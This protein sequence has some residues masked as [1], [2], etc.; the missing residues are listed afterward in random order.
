MFVICQIHIPQMT[1][2]NIWNW[3]KKLNKKESQGKRSKIE[4]A[5]KMLRNL[6]IQYIWIWPS[7]KHIA[8]CFLQ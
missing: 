4:R 5:T 2:K 8:I 6:A 7:I 1:N 3:Q